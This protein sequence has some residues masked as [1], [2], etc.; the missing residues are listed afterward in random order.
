MSTL[1]THACQGA[2]SALV[3]W[4]FPRADR[5]GRLCYLSAGPMWYGLYKKLGFQEVGGLDGVVEI[6]AGVWGGQGVQRHVA[7]IRYPQGVVGS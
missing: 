6:D 5:E 1:P 3:T 2:A 7:M 4:I